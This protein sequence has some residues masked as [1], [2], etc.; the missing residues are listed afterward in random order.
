MYIV[1][2]SG[3]PGSGKDSIAIQIQSL[4][5]EQIESQILSLAAPMRQ[6]GMNFLGFNPDDDRAYAK[7]K[8]EKQAMFGGNT[9]REFMIEI[10]ENY[11][12]PRYGLD[13]W[14][15]RL[16]VDCNE[17]DDHSLLLIP[18]FGFMSEIMYLQSQVGCD[19]V[20]TVQLARQGHTFKNDSRRYVGGDNTVMV[21][22][23]GTIQMAAEKI[24]AFIIDPLGWSLEF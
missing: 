10:S 23:N 7:A 13:F 20:L 19:N 21:I 12:K 15:R 24:I 22:N 11:I 4:L 16:M 14:A 9:L 6:M 1:G 8:E 2:F 18:D 3:P 17:L 5:T